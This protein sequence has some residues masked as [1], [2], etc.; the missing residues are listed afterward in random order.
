AAS[1]VKNILPSLKYFFPQ[2]PKPGEKAKPLTA[3]Q[4]AQNSIYMREARVLWRGAGEELGNRLVEFVARAVRGGSGKGGRGGG[5]SKSEGKDGEGDRGGQE[6]A[7]DTQEERVNRAGRYEQQCL[8]ELSL[9]QLKAWIEEDE[10]AQASRANE[11]AMEKLK[12]AKE[13]HEQFVKKKD[14]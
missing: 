9:R 3:D 12:M 1:K 2:V 8:Q 10:E 5:E 11:G 14:G 4:R 7:Y 13:S 6:G